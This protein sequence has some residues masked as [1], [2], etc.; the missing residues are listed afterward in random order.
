MSRVSLKGSLT[1]TG[2]HISQ[3]QFTIFWMDSKARSFRIMDG[4]NR[5]FEL[6]ALSGDPSLGIACFRNEFRSCII[7]HLCLM[8]R[9]RNCSGDMIDKKSRRRLGALLAVIFARLLCR[10]GKPFVGPLTVKRFASQRFPRYCSTL[11]PS[12]SWN[13]SNVYQ[14]VK[15]SIF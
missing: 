2:P 15:Y 3:E 12:S 7:E 10:G 1:I 9:R 6:L 5:R 11:L 13:M 8:A 4:G 14:R